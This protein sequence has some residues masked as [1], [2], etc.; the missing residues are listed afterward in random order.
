M[1]QPLTF[2]PPTDIH[3]LFLRRLKARR[4]AVGLSQ[5]GLGQEIGLPDETASARI[6]RYER[7]V[8]EPDLRTAEAMA[9]AL[10]VSLSYLVAPDE[11]TARLLLA[12]GALPPDQK[13][14]ALA[15]VES[16]SNEAVHAKTRSRGKKRSTDP[17]S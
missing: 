1:A 17:Q 7:G 4:L 10:G 16:I 8:S 12:F 11:R 2:M 3:A 5:K 9:Q 14:A 15:Q 6:N 13:D